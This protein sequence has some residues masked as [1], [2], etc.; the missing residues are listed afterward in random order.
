MK[1]K[2]LEEDKNRIRF[3]IQGEDHTLCNSLRK[4]LW[5]IKGVEVAGYNVEHPLVSEPVMIIETDGKLTPRDALK[6]V[7]ENLK[8]FNKEILAKIG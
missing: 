8:K 3:E 4:E 5:N 2:V 6:K 1:I 7:V